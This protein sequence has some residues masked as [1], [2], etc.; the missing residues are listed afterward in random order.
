MKGKTN[1]TQSGSSK[2]NF[3]EIPDLTKI[4]VRKGTA[5]FM[6][7]KEGNHLQSLNDYAIANVKAKQ[8]LITRKKA[9]LKNIF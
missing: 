3:S 2:R 7:V 5:D 8:S 9:K 4:N 6:Q 1:F